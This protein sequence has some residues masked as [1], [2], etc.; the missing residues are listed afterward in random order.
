MSGLAG[1]VKILPDAAAVARAAAEAL[2][3]LLQAHDVQQHGLCNVALSGGSTPNAMYELL[4]AL[5][6][7]RGVRALAGK[8]RFF[9][10]DERTV[11][12]DHADSNFGQAWSRWL[13]KLA[14]APEQVHRLA[15]EHLPSQ[16]AQHYE[17]LIR[18]FVP[19][20]AAGQPR[21]DLI[22]LGMGPD[23]HTA[24]LF[25]DTAALRED[26]RLVVANPVPQQNTTRLTFTFPLINAAQQVWILCTGAGKADAL[27][28]VAKTGRH[29]VDAWPISRVRPQSA[30]TALTWWLDRPAAAK[31]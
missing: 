28:A 29:G 31:L 30:E 22:L 8:A 27:A 15:G 4:A 13:K 16:A 19:S 25:P 10:S 23:A 14:L 11:P 18:A 20:A 1:Q 7:S 12:P 2:L 6:D 5:P 3:D 21:F 26:N 17:R 24:S 9:W